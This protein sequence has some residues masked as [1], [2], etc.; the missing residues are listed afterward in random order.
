MASSPSSA[1]PT[2]AGRTSLGGVTF[3][4]LGFATFLGLVVFAQIDAVGNRLV[5][6]VLP[7]STYSACYLATAAFAICAW[8]GD[9]GTRLSEVP[10]PGVRLAAALLLWAGF[11]WTLSRYGEPGW[12]YLQSFA[13]AA[14]LL[15]LAAMLVDSPKR[16]RASLWAMAAAG[17]VS[18]LIV[19]LDSWTG[20]RLVSTAEAAA[21]AQYGGVA[22]SAGGSDENPTTA[23]QMLLVSTSLLLGLFAALPKARKIAGTAIVLCLGALGLMAAR[24]AVLGLLPALVLF[25][26]VLRRERSFPLILLSVVALGAGALALSPAL[27]E[28][29]L[30]LADWGRDPTLFRRTTYLAVGFDLLQQSP[31]WGIGPGNFPYYFVGDEYRFLPGRTPVLRELHNTYLDVAV[32]LGLIGFALFAALVGGALSGVRRAF[33][34]IGPV[35]AEALALM[36]ALIALLFASFFMPNKDMRYLWL[37]LGLAFQCS[38]MTRSR[39]A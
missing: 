11:A 28:R 7:V 2:V 24:S 1:A 33:A 13:K 18:A 5:E 9:R 20:T 21:T 26:W 30:A 36:L 6:G 38:R 12:E 22:R 37:L 3:S 16:L 34:A 29:V 15:A 39:P 10:A 27:L 32:E 8:A 17:V 23:A 19:Y 31:I 35:R 4:Q 25:L 14:G